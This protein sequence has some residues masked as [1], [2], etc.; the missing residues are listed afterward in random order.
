MSMQYFIISVY[1]G[2]EEEVVKAFQ[3]LKT[4]DPSHFGDV[5][6]PK[7]DGT[8]AFPGYVFAVIDLFAN[9]STFAKNAGIQERVNQIDSVIGFLG[10]DTPRPLSEEE[11]GSLMKYYEDEAIKEKKASLKEGDIVKILD[12]A[13]VGFIGNIQTIEDDNVVVEIQ[14]YDESNSI[15]LPKSAVELA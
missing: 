11:I 12:G 13:F 9:Y 8:N 2:R 10:G 4:E 15:T 6:L 3:N 5:F 7:K 14:V 1:T